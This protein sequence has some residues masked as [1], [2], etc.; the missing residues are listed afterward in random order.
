MKKQ[1]KLLT[2]TLAVLFV[3]SVPLYSAAESE[4][5]NINTATVEQLQQLP[6]IG[7]ATAIRI[8]EYRDTN[9]GFS[10]VEELLEIRGI[11]ESRLERIRSLITL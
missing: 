11:G 8:I 1:Y 3:F 2:L 5:V 7:E 10:S 6:G 9:G 4:K